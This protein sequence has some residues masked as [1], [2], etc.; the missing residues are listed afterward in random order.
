MI[1]DF[2]RLH[3]IYVLIHSVVSVCDPIDC[4]APQGPLSMGFSWQEYWSGLPFPLAGDLPHPGIEPTSLM[5]P[6]LTGRFFTPSATW[7]AHIPSIAIIKYWVIPCVVQY[8]L[9]ACFRHSSLYLLM[10]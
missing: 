1:H 2:S 7:G 10:P 5:S 4:L 9:V 6:A 3:S 8:I